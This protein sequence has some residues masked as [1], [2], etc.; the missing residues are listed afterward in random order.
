MSRRLQSFLV[1]A[2]LAAGATAAGAALASGSAR[3]ATPSSTFKGSTT[4]GT[5]S[6]GF[7]GSG[8]VGGA[9]GGDDSNFGDGGGEFAGGEGD[10]GGGSLGL[11]SSGPGGALSGMNVAAVRQLQ[12]DL[13]QLGY[14][15]HAV[16]G[17]YGAVTTRAVK[18]FQRAAGLKADGVWGARSQTALAKR[19]A[20]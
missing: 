20:G 16:T 9:G 5:P 17:Y 18:R 14:F 12:T 3:T 15:H 7:K 10:G 2:I 1:V 19:L 8:T 4:S 6:S 11:L 13:A